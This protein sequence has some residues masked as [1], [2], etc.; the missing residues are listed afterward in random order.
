MPL[1]SNSEKL[2]IIPLTL[3]MM[4]LPLQLEPL[5]MAT[6]QL[7]PLKMSY[8][9]MHLKLVTLLKGVLDGIVMACQFSTRLTKN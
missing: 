3:S 4:D 8:V 7:E 1:N 2:N 5:I 6:L 9:D